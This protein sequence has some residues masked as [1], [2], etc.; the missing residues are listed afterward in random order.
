MHSWHL[1]KRSYVIYMALLLNQEWV[2][3][4]NLRLVNLNVEKVFSIDET[5]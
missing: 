5:R 2:S 1:I 3:K 4:A